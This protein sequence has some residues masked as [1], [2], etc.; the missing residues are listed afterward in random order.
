MIVQDIMGVIRCAGCR[1]DGLGW[2]CANGMTRRTRDKARY[3]RVSAEER[4]ARLVEAG[5]ACLARA[6]I[7]GFTIDNICR[8]AGTSRGLISHHF[9][10][11]D[12]LLA[13]VYATVYDK[14]LRNLEALDSG[15]VEI[16]TLIDT[17]LSDAFLNPDYLNVWLALWAE[18]AVNPVLKAEHR[19]H[20]ALY[21]ETIAGAI[22]AI[23][24]SQGATVDS[25][26][27][28]TALI[29]LVDGL[30]LEQSIDSRMLPS[31]RARELC[32][33]FLETALGGNAGGPPARQSA[34]APAGRRPG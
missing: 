1:P 21:R 32:L 8:E 30:W 12:A 3:R 15:A 13:A 16:E 10:S 9:G 2:Y 23:A 29:S 26:E 4:R 11:K 24:K 19:K 31:R 17:I 20:Y 33:Y 25:Y 18:I 27:I 28:A 22:S 14:A 7:Q 5:I 6:G 34:I